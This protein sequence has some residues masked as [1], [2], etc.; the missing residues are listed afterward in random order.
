MVVA[1]GQGARDMEE[2]K[3]NKEEGICAAALGCREWSLQGAGF[4]SQLGK[5]LQN[6]FY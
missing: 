3:L 6:T 4:S 5:M 2:G 1:G